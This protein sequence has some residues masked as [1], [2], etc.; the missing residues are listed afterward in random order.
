MFISTCWWQR[1]GRLICLV[2][3]LSPQSKTSR[4]PQKVVN[5]AMRAKIKLVNCQMMIRKHAGA[6]WRMEID[7]GGRS[8]KKRF[9]WQH[10]LNSPHENG[11]CEIFLYSQLQEVVLGAQRIHSTIYLQPSGFYFDLK[12]SVWSHPSSSS[13]NSRRQVALTQAL[14]QARAAPPL[15]VSPNREV[16]LEMRFKRRRRTVYDAVYILCNWTPCC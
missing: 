14:A 13:F 9:V 10:F 12:R 3:V 8:G 6:L 2:C 16:R 7:S 11:P 4:A 5:R 15:P 1:S